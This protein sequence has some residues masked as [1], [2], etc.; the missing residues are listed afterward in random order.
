MAARPNTQPLPALS[1]E[2]EPHLIYLKLAF[3]VQ[4]Y[5]PLATQAAQHAW[6]HVDSLAK[7]LEGE[8]DVRRDRAT[9]SR[10][11]LARFPVIK[12][13]E[14]FRWDWPTRINRLQV[15]NHFHLECIKAKANLILLGG[16][17]LGKTWLAC[18]LGHQACRE[19]YTVVSLRLPRLL[20]ELPMAKGDGRYPKLRA[21]LAKTA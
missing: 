21:S 18:A 6:S 11:R 16:V 12:T 5:T 19:G 2:V 10:I 1:G 13:L 17:G 20:Q 7:L 4:H 9:K 14:Q 15:H 8:V 3:I